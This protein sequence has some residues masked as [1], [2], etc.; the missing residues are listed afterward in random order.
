LS[1]AGA[2]RK[3]AGRLVETKGKL[4]LQRGF[5]DGD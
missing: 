1:D 4:F 3:M 5:G 2:S